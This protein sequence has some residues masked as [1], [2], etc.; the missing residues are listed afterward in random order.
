[1]KY[2]NARK[3]VKVVKDAELIPED[4]VKIRQ[5]AYIILMMSSRGDL[6]EK[7]YKNPKIS[8]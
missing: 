6:H 3:S 7:Q 1:V 4:T 5:D 8:R 2:N